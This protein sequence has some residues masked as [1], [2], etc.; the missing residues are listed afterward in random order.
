MRFLMPLILYLEE[1]VKN[2]VMIPG[3]VRNLPLVKV[4]ALADQQERT[5]A[6]EE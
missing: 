1:P 6:Q 4:E 2:G 3:R 5:L